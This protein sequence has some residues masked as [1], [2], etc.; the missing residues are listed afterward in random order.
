[1][2]VFYSPP[3]DC[4]T[5]SWSFR[6]LLLLLLQ[7]LRAPLA[8][9]GFF[10]FFA[11][12]PSAR[13]S[14]EDGFLLQLINSRKWGDPPHSVMDS[15]GGLERG[16][17]WAIAPLAAV[18]AFAEMCIWRLI[19]CIL[20]DLLNIPWH[21][22][23]LLIATGQGCDAMGLMVLKGVKFNKVNWKGVESGWEFLWTIIGKNC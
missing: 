21:L 11:F 15:Y 20:L 12:L 22:V 2:S 6:L 8:F 23:F 3:V 13:E 17:G 18:S 9:I 16:E 7:V 5:S 1:M 4:V 19:K 10:C 14:L